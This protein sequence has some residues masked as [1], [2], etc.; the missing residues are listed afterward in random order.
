MKL[1]T[2]ATIFFSS[3]W[4]AFSTGAMRESSLSSLDIRS[5]AKELKNFNSSAPE[6]SVGMSGNPSPRV[7]SYKNSGTSSAKALSS[8]GANAQA[9]VPGTQVIVIWI[10]N[11]GSQASQSVNHPPM[12]AGITHRVVVGGSKGLVFE[13]EQITAE[14]GDMVIFQFMSNN[15]SAT[16]SSFENP[17]QPLAEG[18]DSGF[19]PNPNDSISPAPEIAMQVTGSSPI[20]FYCKQGNH[21][22]K[23]MT[24]S[25]N[26]GPDGSG[27]T[28]ADFKKKA[29]S[30]NASANPLVTATP[31]KDQ[32]KDQPKKESQSPSKQPPPPPVNM[33]AP[34]LTPGTANGDGR[35]SCS[36]LCGVSSFPSMGSQGIGSFG[37][38]PGALPMS[39]MQ[40]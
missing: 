19:L 24:F 35:C 9:N 21:C 2:V 30:I 25:V 27:R 20:W 29:M 39:A 11:G 15:H 4:I 14:E 16:Q 8:T 13:P 36:C 17:C 12:A 32:S 31:P 40:S 5:D 3:S 22:Q 7:S 23:G 34:V 10:N 1:V 6:V 18:K 33:P 37:G 38:F 26:P 28:H